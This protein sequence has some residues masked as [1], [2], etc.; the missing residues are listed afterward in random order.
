[1]EL[2]CSAED[3]HSVSRALEEKFG[4]PV[5]AKIIWK[6]QNNIALDDEAGVKL[7][8]MLEALEDSDDVQNVYAN[9]EVS[10]SVLE[11]MG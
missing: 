8:R 4:A 7:L 10:D 2:I 3:L 5:S 11:Q 6:A 9:F 1:H